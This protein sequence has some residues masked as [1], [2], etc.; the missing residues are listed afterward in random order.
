MEALWIV[1]VKK[2]FRDG[3]FMNDEGS[4]R[5]VEPFPSVTYPPVGRNP[6]RAKLV[7]GDVLL[8]VHKPRSAVN[9]SFPR[10]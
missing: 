6:D 9:K 8:C 3:E 10:F 1:G 5:T 4:E 7:K 2:K